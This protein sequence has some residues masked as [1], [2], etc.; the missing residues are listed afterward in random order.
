MTKAFRIKDRPNYY[1]TDKG[2]VYSRTFLKNPK[3]RIKKLKLFFDK[4]GYLGINLNHTYKVHRLVA[5]TFIPNPENKKEV[6]HKNGIKTDNRVE[7]LE[8][9]TP[10]ENI[11]HS[12]D[13]LNRKS[14]KPLKGKTG[15]KTVLQ[16]KNGVVVAEFES[17][18]E[19]SRKTGN[20]PEGIYCCCWGKTKETK[21]GYSW[22]YKQDPEKYAD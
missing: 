11:R 20:S 12:F 13:V 9:V 7:N 6:N 8:W 14:P 16:I 17:V 3:G 19:A 21:Y 22:K 2:D 4:D 18:R 5:Q 15:I 1:I 10:K